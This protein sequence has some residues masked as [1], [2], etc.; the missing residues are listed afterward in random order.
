M[1]RSEWARR[2]GRASSWISRTLRFAI[3]ARDDFDCVLCRGLFPLEYTGVG[4]TLDHVKPRSKGGSNHPSNLVTA[5]LR[6]NSRRKTR[7]YGRV[8]AR[9]RRQL[10]KRI[11]LGLGRLL[12]KG[13]AIDLPS[14]RA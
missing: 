8:R 10:N 7:G 11:N 12:S 5:C 6:C 13:R 3:Y 2:K 4:L 1:T 14:T 9:V